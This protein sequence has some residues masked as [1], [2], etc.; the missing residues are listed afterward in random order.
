MIIASLRD[1]LLADER[2]P[3]HALLSDSGEN[4]RVPGQGRGRPRDMELELEPA[5][6]FEK[7][8]I[9]TKGNESKRGD[10]VQKG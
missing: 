9:T 8:F 7:Y 2:F 1:T 4:L 3:R 6:D 10:I 5:P